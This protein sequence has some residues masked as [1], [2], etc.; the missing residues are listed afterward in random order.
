MFRVMLFCLLMY[1]LWKTPCFISHKNL[2]LIVCTPSD[3]VCHPSA[4]LRSLDS[5]RII[6]LVNDIGVSRIGIKFSHLYSHL[7]T[8]LV[9]STLM[10]KFSQRLC[11]RG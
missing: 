8:T 2:I 11:W 9:L 3:S 5:I 4:I 1:T 10:R 7:Y 6:E